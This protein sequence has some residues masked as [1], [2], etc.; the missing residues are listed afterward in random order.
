MKND[1]LDSNFL[2]Q[3]CKEISK[4]WRKIGMIVEETKFV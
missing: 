1:D 4:D 2:N 3:K